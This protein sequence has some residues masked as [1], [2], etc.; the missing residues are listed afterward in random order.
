[1][2]KNTVKGLTLFGML[3]FALSGN[4]QTKNKYTKLTA[5]EQDSLVAEFSRINLAAKAK[6]EDKAKEMGW[7]VRIVK[8]DGNI[9]ELM[10]LTDAGEPVYYTTYNAGSAITSRANKVYP[11]GGDGLELTGLDV[12]AGIWDGGH[13]RTSHTTFASGRA[14]KKDS[15]EEEDHPTHVAGTIMGNGGSVA[16]ARGIAYQA[17]LVVYDWTND[18]SEM[19]AVADQ[20]VASNHSYG[21]AADGSTAVNIFGKYNSDS[22]ALDVITSNF[23]YYQPVIAAGND[24]GSSVNATKNGNDLLSQF[25]TSKNGITVAAIKQVQNYA[26]ITPDEVELASFTNF[27]PTDDFRIKPDIATKGVNVYSSTATSNS[28]FATMSGT[29]MAAPGITGVIVLLQQHFSNLHP[30]ED[31][32]NE[33]PNYMRSASVRGLLAHTAD[34][35]GENDGPDNKTGWGLVNAERSA[36]LISDANNETGTVVFDERTLNDGETYNITVTAEGSTNLTATIAWTDL[37]GATS[38]NATDLNTPV[39]VN[40]LDLRVTDANNEVNY[41]WRLT[42]SLLNSLAVQGDNNVDN[43]EKVEVYEPSGTYT[44]TVNHKN[45]L[46]GGSQ[47]YTL[48]VSGITQVNSVEKVQADELMVWP[49]PAND[50]VNI[51]LASASFDK[52]ALVTVFDVQGRQVLSKK[53]TSSIEKLDVSSL[54][55]GVYFVK[56][57]NAGRQQVKKIMVK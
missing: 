23:P 33:M 41:P 32:D 34:E 16:S 4:A 43:I 53:P 54:T 2:K 1:M 18:T 3:L 28:S 55:S 50:V 11:G 42:T 25:G 52:D 48:I 9:K 37:P 5:R 31:P 49:N 26:A 30:V 44:I 7:P 45:S 57:N 10:R 17:S 19:A 22:R 6:A 46:V 27:G 38:G 21:I 8:E 39:L 20:I 40:N 13:A 15:S 51:Q 47:D 35:I 12:T 36:L 56:L 29:S 14:Q 24:R